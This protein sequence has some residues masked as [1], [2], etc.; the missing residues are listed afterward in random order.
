MI[1]FD[2]AD[3]STHNDDFYFRYYRPAPGGIRAVISRDAGASWD[4]GAPIVLRDDVPPSDFI[5][6]PGSVQLDDGSVF[7]FYNLVRRERE[8]GPPHGYI[9]GCVYRV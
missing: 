5:G 1:R 3:A 7:T 4:G 6:G 9:A 8:G 2:T